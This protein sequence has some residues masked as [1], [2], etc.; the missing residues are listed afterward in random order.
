MNA[1][2]AHIRAQTRHTFAEVRLKDAARR[3]AA[4]AAA[5]KQDG[6]GCQWLVK[7]DETRQLVQCG[8]VVTH[9]GV[10]PNYLRYCQRHAEHLASQGKAL[11]QVRDLDAER[12]RARRAATFSPAAGECPSKLPAATPTR[13]GVAS[14]PAPDATP[15]RTPRQPL[16]LL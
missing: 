13:A 5:L 2:T 3:R 6:D 4:Q 15:G 1:M 16:K 10:P 8:Q 14:P 9:T 11:Y 12:D 7:D